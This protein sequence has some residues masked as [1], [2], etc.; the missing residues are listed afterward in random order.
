MTPLHRCH[1]SLA[2]LQLLACLLADSLPANMAGGILV[3]VFG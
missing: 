3:R 2:R 1:L